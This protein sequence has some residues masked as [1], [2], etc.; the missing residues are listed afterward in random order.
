M[1]TANRANRFQR[2]FPC[3]TIVIKTCYSFFL[4]DLFMTLIFHAMSKKI[5]HDLFHESSKG[6]L[7][8]DASSV[9]L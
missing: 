4:A 2:N 5:E 7:N 8:L 3:M 6:Q 9:A 1:N